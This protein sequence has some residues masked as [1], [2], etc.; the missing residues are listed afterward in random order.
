MQTIV[1]TGVVLAALVVVLQ[2]TATYLVLRG[3]KR[4]LADVDG[5]LE[6]LQRVDVQLAGVNRALSQA[7]ANEPAGLPIGATAPGFSLPDLAGRERSLEEFVGKPFVLTFFSTTCGFCQQMAP[8]LGE[9]H[10]DSPRMLLISRGDVDAHLKLAAE[11]RWRCDVLLET[12]NAVMTAYKAYGTPTGYLIDAEGRIASELAV[13]ADALFE[14]LKSSEEN[15]GG[16]E[17]D[18]TAESLKARQ[19]TGVQKA[20]D[21]GLAV[22]PSSLKRDGLAPGTPAPDFTLPDLA[23]E[24]HCLGEFRNKRVLLV[25]SDPNCGPCESLTD[26]LVRVQEA[27]ADN[28]LQVVMISRGDQQQNEDKAKKHDVRFPVLLQNS[29]EVSRQYAMFATPVGYLIDENGVIAKDVAI[30]KAGILS[31]V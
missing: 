5:M 4:L 11:N 12:G 26:D 10:D 14:L 19:L 27:H 7:P 13:G 3:Q 20:R 16:G 2:A 9:L 17:S 25:F 31:L 23:G 22:R 18:L 15:G 29:W 1:L 30:G 6:Y 21:A 28:N 8:R 24:S